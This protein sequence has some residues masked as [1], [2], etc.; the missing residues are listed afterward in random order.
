M[1]ASEAVPNE[2][3]ENLGDKVEGGD[4]KGVGGDL[5][6][7]GIVSGAVEELAIFVVGSWRE[8]GGG[9]GGGR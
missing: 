6:N 2:Q 4:G 8:E 1:K 9:K 5:A 3:R 7:V